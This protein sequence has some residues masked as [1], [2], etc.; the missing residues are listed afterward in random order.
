MFEI[1]LVRLDVAV[2]HNKAVFDLRLSISA[3]PK[4]GLTT[5]QIIVAPA[6]MGHLRIHAI[7]SERRGLALERVQLQTCVGKHGG[8][9]ENNASGIFL[10]NAWAWR[11]NTSHV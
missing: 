4:N 3:A 1:I 10:C 7:A 5:W 9:F 11:L 2:Q 6:E 8:G